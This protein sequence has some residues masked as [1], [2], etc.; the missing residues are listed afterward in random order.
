MTWAF[1][2]DKVHAWAYWDDAFSAEECKKIIEENTNLQKA[3]IRNTQDDLD[4]KVRDSEICWITP[5]NNEWIY[6]RLTNIITNLNQQFFNFDLFGM[7]EN[8]QF[9]KYQAPSGFYGKHTDMAF[10]QLI[11]KLSVTVQL[12]DPSEYEGG[13]L[14]LHFSKEPEAMEKQ[15]G[16]L[17]VFPSFTLHEVTPVTKGTRYSLVAW[18]TGNQF[19]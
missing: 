10:G 5:L 11:R 19:K 6:G 15:I 8:L 18:I 3:K 7:V 17:V 12:S 16:R 13:D 2:T 14:I 9:T 1:E 4:T